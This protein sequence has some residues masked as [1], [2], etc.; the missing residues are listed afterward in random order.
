MPA[1]RSARRE[2]RQGDR[3]QQILEAAVRLWTQ[4]G[5]EATTV[6]RVAQEAGLAKG[7]IYLY[8]PTK[9]A[10]FAAAAE[11]WSLLPDLQ[12]L[13]PA[14][15]GRPFEAALPWLTERLWARLREAAPLVA[16]LFRELP[17]RPEESRRFLETVVLPANR[18]FAAFLDER[19][20][21]GELR[22]LDTFVA[23][24][25]LVGMLVM[26]LWTQHVLG[27]ERL[28]PIDDATLHAT[29]SGLFLRGVLTAPASPR[30]RP[31]EARRPRPARRARPRRS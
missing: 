15:R 12:A 10:L 21:A 8:F 17:L 14:L 4:Q 28:R 22:P 23:A 16:L 5:F 6:E 1:P 3:R 30:P 20:R 11:R 26:L 25:A 9:D 19:V 31:A 13:L 24:R 18:A 7:T 2:A 29:V 27:G